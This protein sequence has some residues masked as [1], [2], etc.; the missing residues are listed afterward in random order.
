MQLEADQQSVRK[1]YAENHKQTVLF[2]Y[3]VGI[4]VSRQDDVMAVRL[5][6]FILKRFKLYKLLLLRRYKA[7]FEPLKTEYVANTFEFLKLV[8]SI[9]TMITF[10][11]L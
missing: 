3:N 9:H 4:L 10:I 1:V 2:V 6:F 11:K 5:C 8:S 7:F